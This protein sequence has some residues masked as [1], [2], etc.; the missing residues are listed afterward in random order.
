MQLHAKKVKNAMSIHNSLFI[1]MNIN[2][3]MR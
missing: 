1:I 3:V 2:R